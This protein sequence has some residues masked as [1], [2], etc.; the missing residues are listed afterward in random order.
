MDNHQIIVNHN[1]IQN[2]GKWKTPL[3]IIHFITLHSNYHSYVDNC[4]LIFLSDTKQ[5]LSNISQNETLKRIIAK[6]ISLCLN[7]L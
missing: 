6:Y 7:F 4:N 2:P 1:K 5:K 3:K